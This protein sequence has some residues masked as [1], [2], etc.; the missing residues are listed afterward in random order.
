MRRR[1]R[2]VKSFAQIAAIAAVTALAAACATGGG[3]AGRDAVAAQ[4]PD[5]EPGPTHQHTGTAAPPPA[6][7]RDGERFVELTMPQAYT[8][9]APGGVGTD[10]YR[11]FLVDPGLADDVA[12]TGSQFLPDNLDIVHHAIFF[13]VS[14]AEVESARAA[15]DR[16]PGAGWTCFGDAGIGGN[17]AWVASWAPGADETLFDTDLGYLMPTG[18]QL[19]MQI[20]YNLLASDGAPGPQDRS[21]IRLR[22]VD[23]IDGIR[24]LETELL[25]A[26]VELPCAPGES[27]ALCDRAAALADV[28]QRF[29]PEV[30]GFADQLAAWCNAGRPVAAGDT[31]S[32]DHQVRQAG[33]LYGLGGH[34]HLLGRSITVELN[35]GTDRARTLLDVPNYDFDHQAIVPLDE[36]VTVS[37]GDTYRVTCTHDVTLR[38]R[39]PQLRDQ[40]ARYVVWGDGTTDEMC[41]GLVIW[42]PSG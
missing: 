38:T 19:V 3:T 4:P 21:G 17:P 32:C 27:G 15:D 5:G 25:P 33:T 28:K 2:H 30:G 11:C 39:L 23:D 35:P 18:S 34:M 22:V 9:A 7:L 14:P 1:A 10:E 31:G 41:L 8:P 42:T 16:S 6:P 40:P 36:P 13:R 37:P 24:P 29:G 12:L 20:H 26:P